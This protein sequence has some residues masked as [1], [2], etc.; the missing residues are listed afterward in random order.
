MRDFETR[1][2]Q[3][4][5]KIYELHERWRGM[6]GQWDEISKEA[7]AATAAQESGKFEI[8]LINA[9]LEELDRSDT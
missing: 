8:A 9:I 5:R 1:Y 3:I 2:K 6:P 7:I 4:Y